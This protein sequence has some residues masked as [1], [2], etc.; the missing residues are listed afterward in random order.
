MEEEQLLLLF[1]RKK[2]PTTYTLSRSIDAQHLQACMCV[3]L[4]CEVVVS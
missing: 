4:S 3:A 2:M 1:I